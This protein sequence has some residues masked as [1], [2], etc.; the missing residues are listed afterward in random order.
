[1]QRMHFSGLQHNK[2]LIAKR[3]GEG[4]KSFVR[5]PPISA[6][7]ESIFKPIT[8]WFFAATETAGL[9]EDIF[10]L[11][12]TSPKGFAS[13]AIAK[14]W[15][16]VQVAGKP[17][18]HFCFSPHKDADLSLDPVGAAIDQAASSVFF[19]I[20]FLNQAASGAVREA[21]DRLRKRAFSAMGYRIEQTD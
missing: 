6:S 2:V 1:M 12:F 8:L 17:P 11:A 4:D 14:Q 19:S 9:F 20:A 15:H 5:L 10:D 3:N 16:L 18:V 7:A 13:N 21:I